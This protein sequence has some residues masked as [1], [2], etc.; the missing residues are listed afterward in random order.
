MGA[1]CAA[2]SSA[3]KLGAYHAGVAHGGGHAGAFQAPGQL[4][5]SI[6]L[7]SFDWLK[8]CCPE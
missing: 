5:V 8:A 1:M 2:W 3:P 4:V 6:T 7:A